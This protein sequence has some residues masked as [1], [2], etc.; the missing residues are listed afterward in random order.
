MSS[1]ADYLVNLGDV[2]EEVEYEGEHWGAAYRSLTPSMRPRGG[3]LGLNYVRLEKGRTLCPFHYHQREDEV[4]YVISGRGR[5]RYG[6]DVREIGAGDCIS[7]PAGTQ[8]AHQIAN[9]FDEDLVY[10]AI[11]NYEP[12]EVAVYPDN[13]KVLIRELGRIGRLVDAE[14]LDGEPIVP[15]IFG[16]EC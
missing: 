3:K 11:G 13:G 4:F 14:Y 1:E 9:P 8:M 2:P 16:L 5:L 6:H 10:L 15:K 12:D 7:C